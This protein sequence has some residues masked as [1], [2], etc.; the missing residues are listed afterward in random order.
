MPA[1][2]PVKGTRDF[3][4]EN[5]AF[6]RWLYE[7]ISKVSGQYGYQ[8]FEGP[9]LERLAL[10]AAKSGEELVKEQSFVF[11]DRGGDM[12][13]LRPELTPTLARMVATRSGELPRPIRWWSFGPFWR[14]ERPQKGRSREFYQWNIDLL[15]IDK[16]EAD[17]EI[18]A[19]GAS[20][21]ESVGLT[22]DEVRIKINDRRL[23]ESQLAAIGIPSRQFQAVFRLIDRIEK[24][25]PQQWNASAAEAELDNG[26]INELRSILED[27][28]A[29]RQSPELVTFFDAVNQLGAGPYMEYDPTVI[30]GLDYYTGIVFEA[31]DIDGEERSIL[32]GGRYDDLVAEVGGDPVPGVGFAMGDVVTSIVINKFAAKPELR[33]NPADVFVPTFDK[34]SIADALRLST[35]LRSSDLRVEWYPEVARLPKQLKYADRQ[36]IP[37]VAIVGPDEIKSGKIAVKDLRTGDQITIDRSEA[38]RKIKKLL[39]KEG[40]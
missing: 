26:Q 12:V 34:E 22:P 18:A 9:Y 15:G 13:A 24:L 31:R 39:G 4:P 32:G 14:Y 8:E 27:L 2:P 19:I 23:A 28:E 1:I 35:D 30:R 11:P 5:M 21:F 36:G 29:W 20:F 40:S 3:Y 17:A 25:T 33:S 37:I 38:P 10:Y 16:P 6:R 7:K